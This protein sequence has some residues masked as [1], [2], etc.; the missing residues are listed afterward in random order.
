MKK[1]PL[2]VALFSFMLPVAPAIAGGVSATVLVESLLGD[3]K[4]SPDADAH[5]ARLQRELGQQDAIIKE[6]ERLKLDGDPAVQAQIELARRQVVVAAYWSNFFQKNPI[7]ESAL[8]GAYD[9]LKNESGSRQ[10]HL[11]HILVQSDAAAQQ[12]QDELKRKKSFAD[13][14]KKLS[15]DA[16]SRD[17]GGDLGWHWKTGVSPWM[18]GKL[19]DMKPGELIGPLRVA[20]DVLAIVKLEGTRE[21]TF[22]D[23]EK[24]KPELVKALRVQAEQ[25]ELARLSK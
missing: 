21:Q 11:S 10:Y 16:G 9:K 14:A 23:F 17:K 3:L 1:L 24:L 4:N 13:V 12:V 15:A 20:P 19:A 6:A 18:A 2:I 25:Q 8:R 22:P 7:T 5:R